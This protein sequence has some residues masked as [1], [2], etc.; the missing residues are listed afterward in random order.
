MALNEDDLGVIAGMLAAP[1]ADGQ[2]F[3]ALRARFPGFTFTRCDASDVAETPFRTIGAYDLHLMDARDHC[4]QLTD[5]PARATG[6]V[7]ARRS[8]AP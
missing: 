3:P 1:A 4:V 6:L 7:L 8:D 5:D 2:V